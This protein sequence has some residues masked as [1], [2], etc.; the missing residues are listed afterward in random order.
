MQ[1][2]SQGNYEK[3]L[4]S[5]SKIVATGN[6]HIE[7][8]ESDVEKIVVKIEN[9]EIKD[10][11]AEIE[12][13]TL[14]LKHKPL[15]NNK[16]KIY[17]YL[18]YKNINAIAMHAGSLIYNTTQL[19]CD[20]LDIKISSGGETDLNIKTDVLSLNSTLG[21]TLKISGQATLLDLSANS[22]GVINAEKLLNE[23]AKIKISNG[24]VVHLNT[25]KKVAGKVLSKAYLNLVQKPEKIEIE[26]I[27]GGTYDI[28]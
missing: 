7:L 23:T 1:V 21:G 20:T 5:F 19:T 12:E 22:G 3:T 28:R 9:I 4:E 25:S 18:Y 15:L 2:F 14:K 6:F 26:T 8:I 17:V 11:N 24:S 16:V 13:N 27:L 10:L